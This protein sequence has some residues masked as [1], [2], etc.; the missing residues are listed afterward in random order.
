MAI[1][2]GVSV[3]YLIRLEQGRDRHPST[4][5][6]SALADALRMPPSERVH[7]YRLVKGADP[8]FNCLGGAAP[9]REVRPA[10]RAVLD[11]LAPAPAAVINRLGEV[12]ACTDG[13]VRVAGSDR[14][15]R[16][17]VAGQHSALPVH[18]SRCPRRVPGLGT[19]GRQDRR[20]SQG[21]PVSV[22]FATSRS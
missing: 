3:E 19:L 7:L 8:S 1:L 9:N 12:L 13:Y 21:G 11:Q 6:V 16:R 15:A 10:V 20:E 22:G 2:A 14:A 17:R 18:R 5:V 4:A